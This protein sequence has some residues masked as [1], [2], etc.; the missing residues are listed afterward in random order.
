MLKNLKQKI[1][2]WNA[3]S[4]LKKYAPLLA[5]KTPKGSMPNNS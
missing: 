4:E 3:A 1:Q 2:E 5:K